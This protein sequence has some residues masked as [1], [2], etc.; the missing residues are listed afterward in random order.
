[1]ALSKSFIAGFEKEGGLKEW[2]LA[3]LLAG[4]PAVAHAGGSATREAVTHAAQAAEKQW[5]HLLKKAPRAVQNVADKS[6]TVGSG[7]AKTRIGLK[8]L[9]RLE[10]E[11]GPFQASLEGSTAQAKYNLNK[12]VDLVAKAGPERYIG[13]NYNREF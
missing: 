1:M 12:N 6:V 9:K 4:S 13:F 5:G 11:R 7:A 3:G 2:A 10:V 8:N